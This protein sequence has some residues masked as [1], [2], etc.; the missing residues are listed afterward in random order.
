VAAQGKRVYEAVCGICHGNDGAGKPGQAPPVAGSEWV[1]AK[2]ANRLVHI[3]LEG[4]SGSLM[5][6]GKEWNLNM[7]AMG[8][9]LSDSDLAAVL[10]YLRTSWGNQAG[11]VTADDVKKIRDAI[12]S[13]PQPMTGD[14]LMK[15][16]E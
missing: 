4:L 1:L 14:Q 11:E 9:A 12:G 2:G 10:S 16:P 15:M 7:A 13:H 5:V 3:P 8:V 6:K